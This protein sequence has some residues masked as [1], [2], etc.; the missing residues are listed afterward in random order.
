VSDSSTP[1]WRRPLDRGD[2]TRTHVDAADKH[3]PIE[4]RKGKKA[5]KNKQHSV[6]LP[7]DRERPDR[8]PAERRPTV[9]PPTLNITTSGL[10]LPILLLRQGLLL[11]VEGIDA[12]YGLRETS[13]PQ[14]SLHVEIKLSSRE[15]TQRNPGGPYPPNESD[16]NDDDER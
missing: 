4:N 15:E 5:K 14:S 10:R 11:L 16:F 2:G 7:E 13:G 12:R 6:M 8:L 1:G 9:P 3:D